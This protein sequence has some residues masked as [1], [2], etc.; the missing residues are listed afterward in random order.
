MARVYPVPSLC[1]T[2]GYTDPRFGASGLEAAYDRI[3]AGRDPR[4]V[5]ASWL[6]EMRGDKGQG[7]DLLTTLDLR[8][9]TAA[10]RALGLRAGAVVVLDAANGEILALVSQPG[11]QDPPTAQSWAHDL[12]R[13]DGPFVHRG[14]QGLYPPGSSFKIVTAAAA[15]RGRSGRVRPGL[16]G[17]NHHRQAAD[18]GRAGIRAR[19]GGSGPRAGRLVQCLFHPPGRA[20]GRKSLID[21]ARAFGLGSAPPGDLKTAA[22]MLAGPAQRGRVGRDR[23]GAGAAPGEPVADGPGGRGGGQR[24]G[25]HAPALGQGGPVPTGAE[26]I[27]PRVWRRPLSAETAATL[28]RALEGAV[29][30]GTGRQARAGTGISWEARP[31]RPRRRAEGRTPGSWALPTERGRRLAIAVVV[32]H[33]GSGGAVAAPIAAAV[34]RAA[35][36]ET[37]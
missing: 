10:A 19:S 24:R 15:L 31:A 29:R 35:G 36:G 32:E 6:A 12:A 9:Q 37:S 8:V 20:S 30:T 14:L 23:H 17:A 1:H 34:W 27:G 2:V 7:A 22:G 33:G 13:S 16:S 11:F 4:S 25:N 21:Q 28:G 18:Q 3:L 5:W 26:G